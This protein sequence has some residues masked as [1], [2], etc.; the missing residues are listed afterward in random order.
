M[1]SATTLVG[2]TVCL[3]LT[4]AL[5][6]ETE[7]PLSP[8]VIELARKAKQQFKAGHSAAAEKLYREALDQAPGNVYLTLDLAVLHFQMR[9]L[10]LA[11]EGL[12][13][14]LAVAPKDDFSH[15]MLAQVYHAQGKFEE[16]LR[17]FKMALELNPRNTSARDYLD[18]IAAEKDRRE[19]AERL[20]QKAATLDPIA[21]DST[22]RASFVLPMAGDY[23]TPL[24]KS[25]LK[26]PPRGYRPVW[27]PLHPPV[28]Q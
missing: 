24:E 26:V 13:K 25:R 5:A 16:A 8:A 20:Q 3:A 1:R 15:C 2:L 6:D 19:A 10:N 14:A 23:L 17:E 9:K 12:K 11:E 22:Y 4:G 28:R 27:P 7:A 21:S 18:P